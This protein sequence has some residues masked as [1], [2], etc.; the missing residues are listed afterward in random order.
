MINPDALMLVPTPKNHVFSVKTHLT[1]QARS[2]PEMESVG[3]R[4]RSSPALQELR[5]VYPRVWKVIHI[6]QHSMWITFYAFTAIP[7]QAATEALMAIEVSVPA[8]PL[9]VECRGSV[10]SS[11]RHRRECHRC[12]GGRSPGQELLDRAGRERSCGL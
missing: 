10:E 3:S 6:F 5:T 12:A 9:A 2:G 8:Y 4:M 11:A 1:H 7:L